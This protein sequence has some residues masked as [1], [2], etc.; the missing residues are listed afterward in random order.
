MGIFDFIKGKEKA[1]SEKTE[2]PSPEQKLFSEKCI[3]ILIPTFEKFGFEKHRI[4][5]EEYSS[6]IIY[7]KNKQY[8]K[9]TST[10]YPRDYPYCYNIVFGEGDSEDFYEYDW[11]SIALWKLKQKIEPKLKASEYSFPNEKGINPSLENTNNELLEFGITFLNGNLNLFY[12]IRKE[13][14]QERESYKIHSSDKNGNYKTT[15]E[16]K[17]SEKRKNIVE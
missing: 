14:N 1:K 15:N 12:E 9:I 11:N 17:S 16:L 2:K 6:T 4:E 13:Q 8:L 7:R 10:T 5:I 3:E